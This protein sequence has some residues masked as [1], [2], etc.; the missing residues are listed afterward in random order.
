MSENYEP[1]MD[2]RPWT[3]EDF[4]KQEKMVRLFGTYEKYMEQIGEPYL[5]L[6]ELMDQIDEA[7]QVEKL[8][9]PDPWTVK[10]SDSDE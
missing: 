4:Y 6:K 1:P 8:S 9:E 3:R 5:K 10:R 2:L 7:E